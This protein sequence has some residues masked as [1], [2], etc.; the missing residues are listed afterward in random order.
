MSE[1]CHEI[2]SKRR[3]QEGWSGHQHEVMQRNVGENSHERNKTIE[4]KGKVELRDI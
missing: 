2:Q 4:K 1:C 3:I